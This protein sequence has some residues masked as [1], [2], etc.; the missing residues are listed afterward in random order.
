MVQCRYSE[1]YGEQNRA[2]DSAGF[3][4][5]E[6]FTN[7]LTILTQR[8]DYQVVDFCVQKYV[9][10]T[11]L[12]KDFPQSAHLAGSSGDCECHRM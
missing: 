11:I 4:N 1:T 8:Q 12:P 9:E 6:I 7:T 3:V 5:R 2:R 10:G